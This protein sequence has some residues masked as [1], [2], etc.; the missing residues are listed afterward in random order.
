MFLT[1][2]SKSD[3]IDKDIIPAGKEYII[4]DKF[5]ENILPIITLTARVINPYLTPIVSADKRIKTFE[6]PNLVPGRIIGGNKFSIKKVIVDN[7]ESI[8]HRVIL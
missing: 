6:S 4:D 1:T 7:A 3:C 5:P 8:A 2:K